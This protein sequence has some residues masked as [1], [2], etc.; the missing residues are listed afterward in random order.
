[1][2]APA[3]T[4][5]DLSPAPR[6]AEPADSAD[7]ADTADT[8]DTADVEALVA[9]LRTAYDQG[10][11]RPLAWRLAQLGRLR[12]LLTEQREVLQQALAADLGKSPTEAQVTELTLVVAEI[13]DMVARL[14]R[15]LRPQPVTVPPLLW[16]ARAH[17]QLEP[18][19]VVLVIAPWN[20]PVQLS[21]AP[22]VG[23]LAAGNAVLLK[24]SELAP[25]VSRALAD[26]LPRYLDPQAVA[27]I[28]GAVEVTTT[29]LEQRFDHIFF[30]GSTR[31]GTIV[32][33]AA[34]R[35]L[36][37]V[38]LELGGKSP[39]WVDATAD[40]DGVARR[41]A[42]GK[43]T[44]A[45][46]TCVAPDY[47]LATPDVAARLEP[48]LVA[49]IH[50]L[51][52][53]D[54]ATHPDFGRIVNDEQFT[55][56]TGLLDSGR[57]VTGGQAD[58]ATRYLAPTVLADV[59]RGAAVMA[60]EIFG[61]ILPIV[62]VVDLEDALA[63]VAGRDKPLTL[64]VFSQDP[65]TRQAFTERTSSG[66]LCFDIPLANLLVTELPFGGVGRS[67]TG[68]YHGRHSLTTFS[69]EK[70]IFTKPLH[71]DTMWIVYPPFTRLR[72]ALIHR[73]FPGA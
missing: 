30:T 24:P 42:W 47:V 53:A 65:A 1:V 26:L 41:L 72:R 52:G 56:L 73:L 28:E 63:F 58:P 39:T 19:G 50:R 32:A 7:P 16:P 48:L 59:D 33:T 34:A 51:Y 55:R 5:T 18:L 43:F 31:V 40:L 69:H 9:R 25:A 2:T 44:N 8:A 36:T 27:V 62:P 11:T 68:S 12:A 15:W 4:P 17:T 64:Y 10:R 67:G 29:V 66:S 35:H 71:P 21:L 57:T 23:A 60:E 14:P 38:T 54:P 3:R 22:M 70:A 13:D 61:P 49:A 45:G 37:P 6:P 46:Q 20:Y